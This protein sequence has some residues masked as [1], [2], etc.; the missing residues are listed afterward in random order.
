[1]LKM[2]K[3]FWALFILLLAALPA[4][5]GNPKVDGDRI[6]CRAMEVFV[7][8]PLGVTAVLF[9]QSDKADGPRLGELLLAHTGEQVE[10]ET[11][12]GKRHAATVERVKS[13]FG[14]GLLLF[15]TKEAELAANQ[16]FVV[17]FSAPK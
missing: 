17:Q 15:A 12:D 16:D 9:H 14:R 3:S 1:M 7:S 6:S 2:K 11:P 8:K 4:A 10:I 13:C 5:G